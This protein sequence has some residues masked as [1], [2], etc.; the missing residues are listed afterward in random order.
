M[1]KKK[2]AKKYLK[3]LSKV[4]KIKSSSKKKTK[5]GIS[6]RRIFAIALIVIALTGFFV[7]LWSLKDCEEAF[8]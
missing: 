4:E 3:K 7:W 1:S 2:K 5:R 8:S 6:K